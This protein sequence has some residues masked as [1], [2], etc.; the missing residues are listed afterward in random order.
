M[1]LAIHLE[2]EHPGAADRTV[3]AEGALQVEIAA[4]RQQ[5]RRP[6]LWRLAVGDLLLCK[7]S[8][9]PQGHLILLRTHV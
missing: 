6:A 2:T 1:P 9:R 3:G 8:N 7:P 5:H 4:I